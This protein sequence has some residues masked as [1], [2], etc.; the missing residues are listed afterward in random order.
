MNGFVNTDASCAALAA[1]YLRSAFG[2]LGSGGG[3]TEVRRLQSMAQVGVDVFQTQLQIEEHQ[4]ACPFVRVWA[5]AHCMIRTQ[6]HSGSCVRRPACGAVP[7][8][9]PVCVCELR[10]RVC[11]APGTRAQV[12]VRVRVPVCACAAP[13]TRAQ[14]WVPV[15]ARAAP[16][17]RAQVRAQVRVPVCV[18]DAPGTRAQVLE[19]LKEQ[20]RAL[21]RSATASTV[22]KRAVYH[23]A[24]DAEK[25]LATL[26]KSMQILETTMNNIENTAVMQR[27]HR[28]MQDTMARHEQISSKHS[29]ENALHSEVT[30]AFDQLTNDVQ[31]GINSMDEMSTNI[32]IMA[33]QD[34]LNGKNLSQAEW[35]SALEP[36]PVRQAALGDASASARAPAAA[37]PQ[38]SVPA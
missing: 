25:Q 18:C 26:R 2:T 37:H 20:G 36:A 3:S 10:V 5:F 24:M 9:V 15:C 34:P 23:Q 38:S 4:Q 35:F 12:R 14:V 31:S 16:G 27:L 6:R 32:D 29:E 30:Q 33:A 8:R 17:T 19:R 21:Q 1:R 22:E 11:A 13:G 28:V 7:V